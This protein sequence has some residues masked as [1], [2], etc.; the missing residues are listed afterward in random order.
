MKHHRLAIEGEPARAFFGERISGPVLVSLIGRPLFAAGSV[1]LGRD[2]ENRTFIAMDPLLGE[3]LAIEVVERPGMPQGPLDPN[4][5]L[6]PVITVAGGLLKSVPLTLDRYSHISTTSGAVVGPTQ[7][8]LDQLITVLE[9]FK[10]EEGGHF[11]PELDEPIEFMALWRGDQPSRTVLG[12]WAGLSRNPEHAP[13]IHFRGQGT[14]I[15]RNSEEA[16]SAESVVRVHPSHW[17]TLTRAI[18]D[19]DVIPDAALML[20]PVAPSSEG[21]TVRDLPADTADL[22]AQAHLTHGGSPDDPLGVFIDGRAE[23]SSDLLLAVLLDLANDRPVSLS[24]QSSSKAASEE[25]IPPRGSRG[26]DKSTSNDRVPVDEPEAIP[27]APADSSWMSLANY[28]IALAGTPHLLEPEACEDRDCA[29]FHAALAVMAQSQG[30]DDDTGSQDGFDWSRFAIETLTSDALRSLTEL[31]EPFSGVYMEVPP[32][33][34]IQW[35]R[36]WVPPI[37]EAHDRTLASIA[38][39]LSGLYMLTYPDQKATDLSEQALQQAGFEIPAWRDPL[40][41]W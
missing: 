3:P 11:D 32:G 35:H 10:V 34:F 15:P 41:D 39:M 7:E 16:P 13:R 23:W 29:L 26:P 37:R 9:E 6:P 8:M 28:A 27:V 38:E 21:F 40:E 24:S 20:L 14:W 2:S 30:I 22:L 33:P 25:T 4:A 19:N 31:R 1:H 18:D 12:Y 36:A 17:R 5:P